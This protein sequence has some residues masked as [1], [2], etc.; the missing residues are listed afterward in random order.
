MNYKSVS[1]AGQDAGEALPGFPCVVLACGVDKDK[2]RRELEVT[3][4]YCCDT[5]N[6][7]PV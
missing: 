4:V 7:E 6:E 1:A 5:R 2:S 3:I